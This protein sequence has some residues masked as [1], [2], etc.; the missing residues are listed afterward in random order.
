LHLDDI[1]PVQ[2]EVAELLQT[3]APSF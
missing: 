2:T 3:G 1:G